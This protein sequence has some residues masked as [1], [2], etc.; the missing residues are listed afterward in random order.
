MQVGMG[1]VP[2][3]K[4]GI[5]VAQIGLGLAVV[6]DAT[7]GVVLFMAVATTLLAPPFL[8]QLYKGELGVDS[9]G[10]SLTPIA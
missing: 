6:S 10:V 7:Y 3:G 2:R 1:M 5:V 4:V 8:A 9:E